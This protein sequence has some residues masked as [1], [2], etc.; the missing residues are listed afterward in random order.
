[1]EVLGTIDTTGIQNLTLA[2]FKFLSEID[3]RTID[4]DSLGAVLDVISPVW[5][6]MWAAVNEVLHTL[7]GF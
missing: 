6:P 2:F 1:M 4:F 3:F 5:K 7:F